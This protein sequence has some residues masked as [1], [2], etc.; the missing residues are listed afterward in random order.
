[1]K[2]YFRNRSVRLNRRGD[3]R[4]AAINIRH[5]F[6]ETFVEK[7]IFDNLVSRQNVEH[8]LPNTT[9]RINDELI[10]WISFRPHRYDSYDS[11]YAVNV[12]YHG[13]VIYKETGEQKIQQFRSGPDR[14]RITS[15]ESVV[16]EPTSEDVLIKVTVI[17]G[18]EREEI[19]YE[20]PFKP[21]TTQQTT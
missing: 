10:V 2:G 21:K 1:M 11:I 18:E 15:I 6:K 5:I 9:K 14:I 7:K 16:E 12:Y 4:Q 20:F 19:T 17:Q 13:Q 8:F 3:S